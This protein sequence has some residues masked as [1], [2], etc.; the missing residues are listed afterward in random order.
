VV[1]VIIESTY[2]ELAIVPKMVWLYAAF[3]K[4]PGII[5]NENVDT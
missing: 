5:N 1:R 3:A 2:S 4:Y